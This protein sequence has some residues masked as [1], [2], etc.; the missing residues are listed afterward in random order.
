MKV[1]IL[2]FAMAT[3][4]STLVG[5]IFESRIAIPIGIACCIVLVFFYALSEND[6]RKLKSENELD[7]K[8]LRFQLQNSEEAN[9]IEF[10]SPPQWKVT[11][12]ESF[13]QKEL[14][15]LARKY[16]LDLKG[17]RKEVATFHARQQDS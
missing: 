4:A 17:I 6:N 15:V 1:K 9:P 13:N 16:N 5:S 8:F 2:F 11:L 14:A 3:L 10:Q 7:L 12:F